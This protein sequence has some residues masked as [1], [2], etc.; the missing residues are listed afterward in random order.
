MS[1]LVTP[2]T[3]DQLVGPSG[4]SEWSVAQ[5]LSH[6]GSGSEIN[7]ATLQAALGE[8]EAPDDSFN[9]SVWDRWNAMAPADQRAGFVQHGGALIDAWEALTPERLESLEVTVS[10]LPAPVTAAGYAG[11]RLS[12]A[13]Q[14]GWDARVALDAGTGLLDS[15]TDVLAEH[16]AGDLG[17]LLGFIGKG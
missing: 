17:Y 9:H 15:S 5:V 10:F 3:S 1:A 14:H 6:L 7:L 16:L 13:A 8:R 11:M 12:E 2:L 4:A